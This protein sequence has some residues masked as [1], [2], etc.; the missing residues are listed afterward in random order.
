MNSR[1]GLAAAVTAI[2]FWATG[3][4]IVREV[5]L[6][7]VQIAFWRILLAA[8][9]YWAILVF[10]GRSLSWSA[11]KKSIPAGITI[12]LEIALFFV[13]IKATTVANTTVIAALQPIVLLA[14]GIRRFGERITPRHIALALS[15]LAGVSLVV[16]GSSTHPIW[17]PRGDVLAFAAMLLF[18]AYYVTAKR[19]R[20][21]VPALEFQT[22]VWI[23]GV[24]VLFPF[25]VIDA[26]GIVLPS[27]SNWW[28]LVLLLLIP[29]T[30]HF[31]MNWAHARVNLSVT[32]MLTLGI[33]VISTLA[34]AVVL[35]EAIS[36]WQ[37]PGILIV[38]AALVDAI[39][40]EARIR[41]RHLKEQQGEFEINPQA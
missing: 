31:L 17:S 3:N 28:G 4:I 38:I 26:G 9:V 13:A 30:G 29:G 35:E 21:V 24:L 16:L 36:G 18:S 20:E 15:A 25:A 39:R 19:A 22:A 1:S 23:V 12:S 37:I 14:F 8:G 11:F 10:S 7:G 41:S 34:A 6:P 40:R 2:F 32:S 27:A 33:P 5:D